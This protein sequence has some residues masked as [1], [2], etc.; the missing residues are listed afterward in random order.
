LGVVVKDPWPKPQV[1]GA[2][3][4]ADSRHTSGP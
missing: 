4:I 2:M 1:E 3:Q